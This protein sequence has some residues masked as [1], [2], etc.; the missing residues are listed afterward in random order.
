M[1]GQSPGGKI[2][3]KKYYAKLENM[4]EAMNAAVEDEL[5]AWKNECG[6]VFGGN[7]DFVNDDA[8]DACET[9]LHTLCYD[10]PKHIKAYLC[11]INGKYCYKDDEIE[12][13][14]NAIRMFDENEL[15][16]R[17]AIAM[18]LSVAYE[19]EYDVMQISGCCQSDWQ[20]MFYPK[21]TFKN[22]CKG[23]VQSLYFGYVYEFVYDFNAYEENEKPEPDEI[24]DA[25]ALVYCLDNASFKE[26]IAKR[27]EVPEDELVV[28]EQS[29][30]HKVYDYKE[31]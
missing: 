19:T 2:Y 24:Q 13:A 26:Q 21:D 18:L 28:Y 17:E 16:E 8:Y 14:S 31:M 3:M 7:D 29:G 22:E 10:E 25:W 4:Q 5:D 6:L 15:S 9:I 12:K 20:D 11:T 27:M 1:Y 23:I 30:Y